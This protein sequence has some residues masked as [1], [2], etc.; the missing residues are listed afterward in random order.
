MTHKFKVGDKV[1]ATRQ[2]RSEGYRDNC[3]PI[4]RPGEVH[5]VVK[6]HNFT[7]DVYLDGRCWSVSADDFELYYPKPRRDYVADHMRRTLRAA[8]LTK[9]EAS[10][11][12]KNTPRERR[13]AFSRNIPDGGWRPAGSFYWGESPEGYKFWYEVYARVNDIH[14]TS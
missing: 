2:V 6:L 4:I 5:T 11:F 14:G 9:D 12:T 13:S 3:V 1:K 10:R 7:S 8:G